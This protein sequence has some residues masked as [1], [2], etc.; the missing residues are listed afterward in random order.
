M[1]ENEIGAEEIYLAPENEILEEAK[2]VSVLS[3]NMK[4]YPFVIYY[5]PHQKKFL[6]SVVETMKCVFEEN[7][8]EYYIF[9]ELNMEELKLIKSLSCVER[10]RGKEFFDDLSEPCESL[11]TKNLLTRN[12]S[13]DIINSINF[14]SDSI[15]ISSENGADVAST[16][17]L[18]SSCSSCCNENCDML[19]AYELTLGTWTAGR[20]SC[21]GGSAWYKFTAK[22]NFDYTIWTKGYLDTIGYLYDCEGNQIAYNDDDE[23]RMNFRIVAPIVKD[24]TYYVCVKSSSQE[25]GI[26]NIQA[27][28]VVF[29]ESVI[30]NKKSLTMAVNEEVRLSATVTPSFAFNKSVIWSSD[31]PNVATIN[32]SLGIVTGKS[33]GSTSVRAIAR[34]RGKIQSHCP[35]TVYCGNGNYRDVTYHDLVMQPDGY[36]VCSKCGYRI[37]SPILQDKDILSTEDYYKVLSCYLSIPYY[38]TLENNEVTILSDRTEAL[39]AVI[40]QIRSK[41]EYSDKYEYVGADGL[42]KCNFTNYNTDI[43]V[44]YYEV[45]SSNLF[46]HNGVLGGIINFAVGFFIPTLYKS[47]FAMATANSSYDSIS[48]L[49][50]DLATRSNYPE[51]GLIIDLIQLGCSADQTVEI[52]DKVI[53]ISSLIGMERNKL[54]FDKNGTL[55]VQYNFQENYPII[56]A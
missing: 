16:V 22:S 29:V 8:E 56:I 54:I 55:K 43:S 17:S 18:T 10:V 15:S 13:Y 11:L 2:K 6:F 41:G 9:V 19:T 25:T 50:S 48:F 30:L 44:N 45:T 27:N 46:I 32:Q 26:F 34:D 35:I 12:D 28:D 39:L 49:L 53:Y 20:I 5:N 51:I 21:P 31:D 38:S 52:S 23:G 7:A 33:V 37:K 24:C 3:E 47:I 36:Y 4:K 42:Y 40:D 14:S 1:K